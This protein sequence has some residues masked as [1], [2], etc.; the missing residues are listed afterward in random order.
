MGPFSDRICVRRIYLKQRETKD[1]AETQDFC[2]AP[3]RN[4]INH[5]ETCFIPIVAPKMG[6]SLKSIETNTAEIRDW[7]ANLNSQKSRMKS[8]I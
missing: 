2:Y 8:I 1:D 4:D 6:S 3:I 5:V 7:D